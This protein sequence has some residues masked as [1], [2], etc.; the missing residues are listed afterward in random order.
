LAGKGRLFDTKNGWF[1]PITNDVPNE[2]DPYKNEG[3][4]FSFSDIFTGFPE[5]HEED[6]PAE[7]EWYEYIYYYKYLINVGA[8]AAP[9]TAFVLFCI[10][11]NLYFN[12][13]W[14]HLWAGGSLW[15]IWET[16]FLMA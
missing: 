15:L 1:S 12:I 5:Y 2:Y 7:A 11:Y 8:I 10:G 13:K 4:L 16:L 9:W 3:A 6:I 14:N